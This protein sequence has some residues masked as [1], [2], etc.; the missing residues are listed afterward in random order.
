MVFLSGANWAA[1]LSASTEKERSFPSCAA[2]SGFPRLLRPLGPLPSQRSLQSLPSVCYLETGLSLPLFCVCGG[3]L[4]GRGVRTP[5]PSGGT[6]APWHGQ[7][8]LLDNAG[9]ALP[10]A[11]PT[12]LGVLSSDCVAF[13]GVR[14]CPSERRWEFIHQVLTVYF[15]TVSH[16]KIAKMFGFEVPPK[17]TYPKPLSFYFTT[18]RIINCLLFVARGLVIAARRGFLVRG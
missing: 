6:Q 12:H 7:S 11:A 10:G 8:A 1:L 17:P 16:M 13:A 9:L 14:I 18:R 15:I 5:R 4:G 3:R 2:V